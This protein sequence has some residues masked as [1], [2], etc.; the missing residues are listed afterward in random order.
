MQR[1]GTECGWQ[2]T[3]NKCLLRSCAS[4]VLAALLLLRAAPA[5][6][7]GKPEKLVSSPQPMAVHAEPITSF[8]KLSSGRTRFGKLEWI[9]GVRLLTED[10]MFGGLSGIALDEDGAG[11]VAVSD[12]GLWL[13]GKLTYDNGRPTGMTNVR[14]GPLKALDGS[15]LARD[16]DRDAE[17]V[18][19][20]D[21]TTARGRLLVSF[22]QNHRIGAFDIGPDG[23]SA[24][25]SYIR[26]DTRRG[27]MSALSGFEAIEV[28]RG[29]RYKG[30]TIAFAERLHDAEGR[31]TGWL[32]AK[33]KWQPFSLTDIGGFDI[34]E[35]A[36]LPDGG[37]MLL[38]RRFRW[39]EGVKMRI[40]RIAASDIAPGARLDGEVLL[41]ATMAQAIDNMEGLAVHEDRNGALI[42]TVLSDDNYNPALQKT[43]LLQFR[44][45]EETAKATA[46]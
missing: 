42:L 43:L 33:G 5:E 23:V 46:R 30:A 9:G 39:T 45:E 36:A 1:W 40:R 28:L 22:E 3:S 2:V 19:L 37:L 13:T 34:T 27:R 11:F 14:V 29:G 12:A 20:T 4:I 41:E 16:R 44:L 31:H 18:V 38:E 8:D 7:E 26:P 32:W 21:G 25:K 10:K 15:L 24:P 35:A 17:A 6:A